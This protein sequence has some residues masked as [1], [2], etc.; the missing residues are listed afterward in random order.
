MTGTGSF[1]SNT[2]AMYIDMIGVSDYTTSLR[3]ELF[4]A[5]LWIY[6]YKYRNSK[7]FYNVT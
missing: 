2:K 5:I 3:L 1:T 7:T 6:W 4:N